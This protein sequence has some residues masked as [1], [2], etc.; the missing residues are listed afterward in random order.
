MKN[1]AKGL[2]VAGAI[3]GAST[4]VA[5]LEDVSP[6]LG[7]EYEWSTTSGRHTNPSV[8]GLSHRHL[9]TK[10]HSGANF[11]VGGRMCN[12]AAEVGY[13]FTNTKKR[14]HLVNTRNVSTLNTFFDANLLPGDK[15]HGKTRLSGWHLDFNGYVPVCDCWELIG[16]VGYGWKRPNVDSHT[17]YAAPRATP[18][19]RRSN[20]AHASY[21]GMVRL[22][23]GAQYMVT[24]CVGFRAMARW[25]NTEKLSVN[26]RHR[27]DNTVLARSVA[28]RPYKDTISL[29]A[30][31][32][33]NF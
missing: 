3:V 30:G 14:H 19:A 23:L 17:V 4:A 9:H 20:H 31:L 18:L 22:G 10:S 15:I 6:Y 25:I 8:R 1:I 26:L 28:L 11:Y 13:A 5:G 2:L 24:E 32:F 29:S 21:K 7:G 16:S 33:V 12:F 27:H